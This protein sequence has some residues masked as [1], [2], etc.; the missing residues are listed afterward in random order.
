MANGLPAASRLENIQRCKSCWDGLGTFLQTLGQ[1][2]VDSDSTTYTKVTLGVTAGRASQYL[3]VKNPVHFSHCPS[4]ACKQSKRQV[5]P[6][7]QRPAGAADSENPRQHRN[8]TSFMA[9]RS[10]LIVDGLSMP[11]TGHTKSLPEQ[12]TTNYPDPCTRMSNRML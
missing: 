5:L 3:A 8:P 9:S 7:S 4:L 12:A 11:A 2:H 6:S 10:G 1:C